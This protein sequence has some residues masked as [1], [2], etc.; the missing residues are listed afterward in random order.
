MANLDWEK[1]LCSRF[2]EPLLILD[3]T[4]PRGTVIG[5][6]LEGFQF[7]LM[8]IWDLSRRS[9]LRHPL[10]WLNSYQGQEFVKLIEDMFPEGSLDGEGNEIRVTED[11]SG[12]THLMMQTAA[13]Y[14]KDENFDDGVWKEPLNSLLVNRYLAHKYISKVFPKVK[15]VMVH[16]APRLTFEYR[17]F[18]FR[19]TNDFDLPLYDPIATLDASYDYTRDT[20]VA[21]RIRKLVNSPHADST[22]LSDIWVYG[23]DELDFLKIREIPHDAVLADQLAF[24]GL[25]PYPQSK[26]FSQSVLKKN[27]EVM[28]TARARMVRSRTG[29]GAYV[30]VTK[31]MCKFLV[32]RL[33]FENLIQRPLLS[34]DG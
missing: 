32:D 1:R 29:K 24:M 34:S 6:P 19:G 2:N 26:R 17:G 22:K 30:L 16:C 18:T 27:Y 10:R 13:A 14:V 3:Y 20:K 25:R 15:M 12:L 4:T 7:D 5:N 21:K 31:E 8:S 23:K 11:F 33:L 9:R 28:A